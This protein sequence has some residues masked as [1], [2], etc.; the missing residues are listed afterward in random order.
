[1]RERNDYKDA[2]AKVRRRISW[3][4]M[5]DHG[6]LCILLCTTNIVECFMF[7]FLAR[8]TI[9]VRMSTDLGRLEEGILFVVAASM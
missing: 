7:F 9:F 8:I 1:M 5:N 4:I 6:W 3:S 2:L